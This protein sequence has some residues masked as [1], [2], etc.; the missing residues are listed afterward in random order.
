MSASTADLLTAALAA[1]IAEAGLRVF[2]VTSPAAVAASLAARELGASELALMVGFTALDGAPVPAVTLGEAGLLTRGPAF[3]DEPGDVFAAL[4]R[5]RAGVVA[6]PAQLD[7]RGRTNLSGVGPPGRPRVALP[8][9]RGLPDHR[10]PS[11]VWYLFA[12]HG[13]RQLVE[14]VDV[15]SGA[16]PPV[17]AIRRLLTPAGCFELDAEG[18]RARWLTPAGAGLVERAPGIG[19]ALTG[20]EPVVERPDAAAL[21]AVERA[22][23]H[24]CREIEFAAGEAAQRLW[25]QAAAREARSA[26]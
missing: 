18:W 15:V 5:G 11:R 9:S 21:A 26:G 22:D 25:A 7:A 1:E 23:P 16:E 2:A 17:G 24:R 6:T 4:A 14:R 13:P 12:Q 19:I 3:R 8:G 20:A 10:A